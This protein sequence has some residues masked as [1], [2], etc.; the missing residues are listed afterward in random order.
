MHILILVGKFPQL[1][2]TFIFRKVLA[3]AERGH[4]ITVASRSSGE[5]HIF[6]DQLPLPPNVSVVYL[7]P[8]SRLQHPSQF[9]RVAKDIFLATLFHPKF[10]YRLFVQCQQHRSSLRRTFQLFLRYLSFAR[11]NP[12]I[13]HF[14]FLGLPE[15]YN[16]LPQLLHAPFV[17]SCRGSDMHLHYQRT[18]Q[19]QATIV[20]SLQSAAAVHVVSADMENQVRGIVQHPLNIWINRPAIPIDHI[21]PRPEWKEN[22][23]PLILATGRLVWIKGFDY[24]LEALSRLKQTGIQFQAKILGDGEL[25]HALRFSVSDLGLSDCTHIVG[26]VPPSQVLKY[27]SN[28]DIFVLSSHRE[29]ISNAVL[30]AMA[31]GLPIVTTDAGGMQ[32]AVRNGVDGFVVPV[33]DIDALVDRIQ[34]LLEDPA[35]RHRMGKAAREHIEAEFTLQRQAETFEAMYKSVLNQNG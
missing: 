14:E 21:I 6:E 13:I 3:L 19:Q 12:E 20:N 16:L 27:M 31:S 5:W 34:R 8:D 7:T 2:E 9:V 23:V 1:S 18:N 30:E 10:V 4:E 35:L 24:F 22:Q 11:T 26:A 25:A 17:V 15:M 28:A 29:G 32:E 33:R